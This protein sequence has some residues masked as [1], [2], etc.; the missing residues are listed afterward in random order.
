[1]DLIFLVFFFGL[2]FAC[3]YVVF[4]LL[5]VCVCVFVHVGSAVI[6]LLQVCGLDWACGCHSRAC[7]VEL[8]VS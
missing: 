8:E 4:F 5:Y 7:T 2:V 6:L 1:M 3:M